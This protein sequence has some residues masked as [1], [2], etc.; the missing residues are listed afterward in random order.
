MFTTIFVQPL[1][2]IL[3]TL[4]GLLPGHD[5]GVAVIGLTIIVRLALWPLVTKQLHSQ[6]IMQKMA[7][8]IAQI[9]QQAK[10]DRQKETQML[11]ELYKERGTS[12][13]APIVPILFQLPIFFALYIVFRDSVHPDKIASLTYSFVEQIPAVMNV[14][15]N[16]AT[17]SA[18]LFGVIDLTKPNIVLAVLAGAVQWYQSKMLQPKNQVMDT[19]AKLMASMIN[20]FPVITAVIAMTLPSAL[21]LYWAVTSAV[22]ILQQHIVLRRDAHEMEDIKITP[23]TAKAAAPSK[24]TTVTGKGD[25]AVKTTVISGGTTPAKAKKKGRSK[26]SAK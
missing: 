8:E 25:D 17:F 4:Y 18:T 19:Q 2:N 16:N 15:N 9:K 22:A 3:F 13:F 12:P 10:G 21:A 20:V 6:K 26:R 23:K 24:V 11:M 14:I 5:F 7:P 1:F